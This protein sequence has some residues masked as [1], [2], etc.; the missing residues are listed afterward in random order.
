MFEKEKFANILKRIK[1]TY[2]SQEQFAFFSGI[3][4]TSISQYMN[5]KL[6]F[7]PKPKLLEKIANSSRGITSYEEL[8]QICG[9]ITIDN[10]T[11][12]PITNSLQKEAN[13]FTIPTFKNNNGELEYTS[14]DIVLPKNVDTSNQYFAYISDD[15]S[16][17]PLFGIGD[18]AIIQKMNTYEFGKIYLIKL[19]DSILLIRKIVQIENGIE[20][21][22]MNPYFP[23]LKLKTEEL[24]TKKFKILGRMIKSENRSAYK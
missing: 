14:E 1:E 8:M 5:C 16:M 20:L 3:G 21:Q 11:L 4:R 18:I 17:A 23:N 7:P 12:T 22:S 24:I 2:D 15:E 6:S 13:F 19:E 9:Y 10:T